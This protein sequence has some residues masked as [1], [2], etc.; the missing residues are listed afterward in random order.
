MEITKVN[1][2]PVVLIHIIVRQLDLYL[3]VHV[4]YKRAITIKWISPICIL[5]LLCFKH[6]M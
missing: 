4:D 5:H 1:P 6:K 2:K 3:E